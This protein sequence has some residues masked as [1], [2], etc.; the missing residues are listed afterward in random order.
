MS[1]ANLYERYHRQLILPGF[2]EAAQQK[3]LEAKILVIGAG[4][5]GCPVL[6]YLTAAGAGTIGIV[7]DDTVQLTNLQRQVIYS[8]NDIGL[9]KAE[10]AADFLRHLN[11]EINILSYN[12]RL[13][14]QNALTLLDEFDII[15]DGTDNFPTRY[16]INDACVLLKKR[17]VYGAISQFEGQLTVFRNQ[18]ANDVDYRDIFP[19]PPKEGEVLNC[20][21]AGVLGVLPGIIGTMMANE[22]I[23]LITGIGTP[24]VNQLL[25]Y[26]ALSNQVFELTLSSRDES[27]SVMP[28]NEA[29]FLKMDYQELCAPPVTNLEIDAD[30][31]NE[32]IANENADVIDV[33]ELHELPEVNEFPNK[34]IP[35][36]QLANNTEEMRSGI[37][38]T[39]CQT[40]KRSFQ[41][42]KI[43]HSI[44]GGSKRIYSLRGGILEWKKQN[45]AV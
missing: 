14:T 37:L 12:E 31:F 42:V 1:D 13:T 30:R 22:T 19:D 32:L 10:S 4:G 29:E 45:Q 28:K 3:L 26:N 17:L 33:R 8:V 20:A 16:L 41:A 27:R 43:L 15:I 39:F 2:G 18:D 21:D 36:S 7:D 11:P 44:F 9:P 25:T 38:I 34:K 35:L 5:L 6:Q 24:L 23:K 40:G